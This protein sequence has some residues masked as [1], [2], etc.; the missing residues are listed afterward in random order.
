[1]TNPLLIEDRIY[2]MLDCG[3]H[4]DLRYRAAFVTNEVYWPLVKE[5]RSLRKQIDTYRKALIE[6]R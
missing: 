3:T 4:N 1:M 5:I 2:E 6:A